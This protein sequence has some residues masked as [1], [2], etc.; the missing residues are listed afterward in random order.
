LV[1]SPKSFTDVGG[2]TKTNQPEDYNLFK[3]IV[4]HGWGV[5]K[6]ILTNLEYRQHS[7]DQANNLVNIQKRMLFY[8][9]NFL[10][11]NKVLKGY[12]N[13]KIHKYSF[14][15]YKILSFIK[16]NYKKPTLIF[17]TVIKKLK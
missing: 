7:N 5:K 15:L 11:I 17:K 1:D 12:Q 16:H 10:K 6:A 14:K 8:K 2:Y 9:N 13:S 4:D 3:R